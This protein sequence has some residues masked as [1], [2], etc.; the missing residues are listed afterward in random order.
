[1]TSPRIFNAPPGLLQHRYSQLWPPLDAATKTALD[2]DISSVG[3]LDAI[4][5]LRGD[6]GELSVLDG[7]NRYQSALQVGQP[8][9]AFEYTGDDPLAFVV[10]K[11]ARRRHLDKSQLASV[12]ARERLTHDGD[13]DGPTVG[14]VAESIGVSQRHF[15]RAMATER[16]RLGL[17][18][19]PGG[20]PVGAAGEME[21]VGE[22]VSAAP[23]ARR[24]PSADAAIRP[25]SHVEPSV[26]AAAEPDALDRVEDV[27]GRVDP[28]QMF[29]FAEVVQVA[30]AAVEDVLSQ[31]VNTWPDCEDVLT[32][33]RR[34][35]EQ[36]EALAEV[37]PPSARLH[38]RRLFCRL[39]SK[40][41]PAT[42]TDLRTACPGCVE[43]M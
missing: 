11:N 12:A 19:P 39:C 25:E 37:L 21:D 6:D 18:R 43:P 32:P 22:T 27:A 24:A 20:R 36:A 30:V 15:Q 7:W 41:M 3:V 14:E 35:L 34:L 26:T 4:A 38:V 33:A 8:C 28:S 9:P 42:L 16:Q 13:G 1:M 31:S 5:L 17:K 10:S 40:A 23:P 29:A 2:D